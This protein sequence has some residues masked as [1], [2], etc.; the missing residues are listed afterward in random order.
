MRTIGLIGGMSWE[1]TATY[2]RKINERIR[3]VRGGLSSAD[4]LLHS[5]DFS[6]V[7]AWQKA[8][9]WQ[10]AAEYLATVGFNLQR[11]GADCILICTNTMHRVADDVS[12]RLDVPLIHIVDATGEA[13]VRAGAKRP[14]LL[15]T[16]YTMEG[17]FYRDRLRSRFGI[18]AKVP[19]ADARA[20]VNEIIF[21]ELCVGRI[22]DISRAD[23]L[24]IISCARA[25][26]CDSVI[27]GCTE[28]GLL[29]DEKDSELKVFDSTRL[30]VEA[31][32][33]F[34]LE[35]DSH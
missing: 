9:A 27:L 4:L 10:D 31:A 11:A 23:Y 32:V 34:A 21:E 16:S 17:G 8:G 28:I 20:T 15:A 12:D 1:S 26:G 25:S 6:R 2:Y 18:E 30:H 22:L 13:L 24:R 5:V 14:L 3:A 35:R 7:V 33:K 29:I 19:D